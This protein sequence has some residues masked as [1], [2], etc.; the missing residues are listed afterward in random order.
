M[1]KYSC[2]EHSQSLETPILN[3]EEP[4]LRSDLESLKAWREEFKKRPV[5]VSE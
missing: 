3:P 1:T 4:E 2:F 5:G